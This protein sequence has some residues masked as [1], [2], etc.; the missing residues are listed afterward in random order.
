MVGVVKIWNTYW[1][2]VDHAIYRDGQMWPPRPLMAPAM[3]EVGAPLSHEQRSRGQAGPILDWA[4][5]CS[6]HS[7]K[8]LMELNVVQNKEVALF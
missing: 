3:L 1:S 7:S 5:G 8:L 2:N 6:L 4:M